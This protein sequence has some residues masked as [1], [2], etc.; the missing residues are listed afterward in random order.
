MGIEDVSV[1]FD[2]LDTCK[3]GYVTAGQLLDLHHSLNF[4]HVSIQHVNTAIQQVCGQDSAVTRTNF[5][6]VLEEIERLQAIHEQAYW[7]FQALDYDGDHRITLK[8]ALM[9][10]KEFHGENFSMQTWHDFLS[11]RVEP[12]TDVFF[13]ELCS[14]LCVLSSG[15]ECSQEQMA[16]ENTRLAGTQFDFLEHQY[17]TLSQFKVRRLNY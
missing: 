15:D 4:S 6:D 7:D 2:R 14:W 10:F 9:L 8:D 5:V 11:S 13:D 1:V 3:L 16:A 17:H 12:N